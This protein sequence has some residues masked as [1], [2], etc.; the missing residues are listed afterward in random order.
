M[1]CFCKVIKKSKLQ[2]MIAAENVR[3]HENSVHVEASF[4]RSGASR[5]RIDD[6]YL[7]IH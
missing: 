3:Y 6:V 5:S 4:M 2:I 1:D 7:K